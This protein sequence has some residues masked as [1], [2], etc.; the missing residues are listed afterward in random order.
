[1]SVFKQVILVHGY[2]IHQRHLLIPLYTYIYLYTRILIPI[3]IHIYYYIYTG[4]DGMVTGQSFLQWEEVQAL[5][6]EDLITTAIVDETLKSITGSGTGVKGSK[7]NY[8]QFIEA[9]DALQEVADENDAAKDELPFGISTDTD[10]DDDG[11]GDSDSGSSSFRLPSS[12]PPNKATSQ[13]AK[14]Y[15]NKNKS[16]PTPGILTTKAILSYNPIATLLSDDVLDKTALTLLIEE[17]GADAKKGLNLDQFIALME[18][19]DE[20]TI[21]ASPSSNDDNESTLA[22]N[23]PTTTTSSPTTTT[24]GGKS[25][26]S[27]TTSSTDP[28]DLSDDEVTTLLKSVYDDLKNKKTNKVSIQS[29]LTMDTIKDAI[30]T[31]ELSFDIFNQVLNDFNLKLSSEVDFV[32][33]MALL[34]K[35]EGRLILYMYIVGTYSV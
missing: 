17:T 12:S 28:I 13:A 21:A 3:P 4:K 2:H 5:I 6:D 20:Y 18:M 26:S 14:D 1:M 34:D 25:S 35:L 30:Q 19:L 33:F 27:S 15:Y 11:D 10:P 23:K 7:L 29:I 8:D 24:S 31:K 32:M 9:F 22:S 16:G